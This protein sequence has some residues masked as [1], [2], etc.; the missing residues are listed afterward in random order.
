MFKAATGTQ[1][2]FELQKFEKE[3][4]KSFRDFLKLNRGHPPS[5]YGLRYRLQR[6]LDLFDGLG[7][8]WHAFIMG[9]DYY[10]SMKGE[11]LEAPAHAPMLDLE[12]LCTRMENARSEFQALKDQ[13]E[14]TIRQK[15]DHDFDTDI[16]FKTSLKAIKFNPMK[17]A[18]WLQHVA[19]KRLEVHNKCGSFL[20]LGAS[21]PPPPVEPK[22][23][24]DRFGKNANPHRETKEQYL[25]KA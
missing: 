13:F 18:D 2:F 20:L 4:T 17:M 22:P 16:P 10:P 11:R 6:Y 24:V 8:G 23:V 19:K 9:R 12:K 1:F 14:E 7:M 21:A 25:K 15:K 3:K 5:I